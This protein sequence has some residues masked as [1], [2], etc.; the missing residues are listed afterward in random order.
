MKTKSDPR[1]ENRIKIMKQLFEKYFRDIN[2]PKTS[3]ANE[4]YSNRQKIDKLIH[5][6]APA[7]PIN[8]ISPVDLATLRLAIW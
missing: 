6:N 7:W 1:H 8:Q 4:I 5:K 2:L 3:D